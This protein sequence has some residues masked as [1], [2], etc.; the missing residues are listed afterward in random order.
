LHKRRGEYEEALELWQKAAR[1]GFIYAHIEIAKVYEHYH[2]EPAQ[3][4]E[5]TEQALLLIQAPG[6]SSIEKSTWLT[7][8]E[9]RRKR[10][11]RKLA[12][13]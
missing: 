7:E 5:W 13:K 3:A 1:Q 2:N 9:H 6:F 8:L 10:L 4:L 12:T 11:Q